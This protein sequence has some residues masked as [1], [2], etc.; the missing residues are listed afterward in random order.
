MEMIRRLRWRVL[1]N[2]ILVQVPIILGISFIIAL[3]TSAI[4]ETPF[5]QLW[6]AFFG[7]IAASEIAVLTRL[8]GTPLW[9][10]TNVRL[11]IK[12]AAIYLASALAYA[13]VTTDDGLPDVGSSLLIF[14]P[15][16]LLVLLYEF[17]IPYLDRR[18]VLAARAR[19]SR[20]AKANH[21]KS[22]HE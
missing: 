7:F 2:F 13:Y 12:N 3:L 20:P 16:L 1:Q 10:V 18:T 22:D 21:G 8:I 5:I 11:L 15:P 6:V 4:A 17:G 14:F 19:R 9:E